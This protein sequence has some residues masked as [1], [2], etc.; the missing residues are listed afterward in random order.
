MICWSP[1]AAGM[2]SGKYR[3]QDKPDENT[4]IGIQA[5]ITLPRYWFDD[6][7]KMIDKLVEVAGRIGRTPSQVALSWLLGDPRVTAAIVGARRVEQIAENVEAGDADL[8]PEVRQE[9][10]DAMP[11]KLG[12]PY[13]WTKGTF[14]ANIERAELDPAHIERLPK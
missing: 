5:A 1:L 10:T 2:L 7:L 12:Y 9:L 13:E 4:R 3:A 11:L 8:A 14:A 6:A